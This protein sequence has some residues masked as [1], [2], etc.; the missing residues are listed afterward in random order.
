MAEVLGYSRRQATAAP[1]APDDSTAAFMREA[2]ARFLRAVEADT[3]QR[4][5]ELEDLRFYAGDQW[6][7]DIK[8]AR[9]GQNATNAMPPVPARPCLTI[10]KLREPVRQVLNQERE[11]DMGVE[12]SP[13]D[14]FEDVG[15]VIDHTEIEL[16]EGLTRRIQRA[17]EAS[18]ARTWA[19]DRAV[20][21]GRGYYAVMLR[22]VSGK[23]WDQEVYVMRLYDQGAVTLDPAHEQ[24]DGS[25]AEFGFVGG[26]VSVDAYR[27]QYP[28][29][30]AH[31]N[32]ISA[33]GSEDFRDWSVEQPLWV[34]WDE[35]AET[36][37]VW[38]VD[39]Y[40][41]VYESRELCLLSTGEAV[42]S[43]DVPSGAKVLD[44]RT[45]ADKQIK[46]AKLDGL[47]DAPLE[48]TDWP[49]P[50]LPIVKVLGEEQ[51]PYDKERR[52]E[53]M[54]RPARDAQHGFNAMVS[55]WVEMVAL[56]PVPPLSVDPEAI[57]GY[58]AWY[59]ASTTRTL[60][61]LPARTYD[62]DGRELRGPA[63]MVRETPIQAV[64][65]S[66]A[67]FD[68]GIQ[69]TTVMHDPAIGKVDPTL[70]SGK[71]IAAIVARGQQGTS[72][73]LD[74][75]RR[76]I[77]YEGQIINNLLYPVYGTRPGR[78]ARIIDG[79]GEAQTLT[80]AGPP[81]AT[82]TPMPGPTGA[83]AAV[84]QPG[85]PPAAA[86]VYR[87]TP[88]AKFNVAVK[89]SRSYDSRRAEEGDF[90]GQ[91]IQADPALL[92][93]FGDLLFKHL[94]VP[95][96][97]ALAERA[98]V[99]LVPPVQQLLQAKKQGQQP[100]PPQI[101]SQI[102]RGGQIIEGLSKTV[103]ELEAEK[104][105]KQ[106]ELQGRLAI[107]QAQATSQLELHREDNETKLAVAELSAKVDRLALFLEERAR[108]GAQAHETALA[109]SD[110]GHDELMAQQAHQQTL[111]QG[112]AD[113]SNQMATQAQQAS[114]QIPDQ[115]D[116]GNGGGNA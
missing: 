50:D 90:L 54:V 96:A 109:A 24:P 61:Y 47:N 110:A 27:A 73:Y 22:Y 35:K 15:Q 23:S 82:G 67:L 113:T 51:Q 111:Q 65:Q 112:A 5:R 81:E 59:E 26:W 69:A 12:I 62:D 63:P 77:R 84:G 16:R 33:A 48:E 58:Q 85:Q 52:V 64:A 6:P 38:V 8:T 21:C 103:Q 91:L 107:A 1:T 30:E 29:S 102:Q 87:L 79:Q 53:G 66:V 101:Q 11:A 14:D 13:A 17:S 44:R 28:H 97:E 40:Y 49:G 95:G 25:D 89:V 116:A 46:W 4:Q 42:W 39:Y 2:R 37:A 68:Q 78:I 74:N 70:K 20:K 94:D 10:N 93:V 88:D 56:T 80:I 31:P 32:R 34:Q 7:D 45:V 86:P 104:A 19:F 43:E 57:D 100:L 9:Q 60:P 3:A 36:G 76:S 83:P 106:V 115:G 98:E 55:K 99:M 71:A 108:L 75:L 18:D 92:G 72:N 105:A 114:F 41:T